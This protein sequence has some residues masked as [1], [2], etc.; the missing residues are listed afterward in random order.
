MC[1]KQCLITVND[2][3]N[4]KEWLSKVDAKSILNDIIEGFDPNKALCLPQHSAAGNN[5]SLYLN[6][7]VFIFAKDENM[8]FF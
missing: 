5:R 8:R 4:L 1:L 2:L 7:K 3:S 6:M